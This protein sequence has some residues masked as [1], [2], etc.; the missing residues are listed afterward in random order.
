MPQSIDV[1]GDKELVE[2]GRFCRQKQ[3]ICNFSLSIPP[4]S[5]TKIWHLTMLCRKINLVEKQEVDNWQT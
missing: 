2:I 3:E 5:T 4:Q 1:G